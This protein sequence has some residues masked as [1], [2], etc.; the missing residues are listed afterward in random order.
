MTTGKHWKQH[1]PYKSLRLVWSLL[2]GRTSFSFLNNVQNPKK[3]KTRRSTRGEY[4]TPS[5]QVCLNMVGELYRVL[6]Q[7]GWGGGRLN[8]L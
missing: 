5:G 6:D 3:T 1:F 8:Y 4:F 2:K 7:A